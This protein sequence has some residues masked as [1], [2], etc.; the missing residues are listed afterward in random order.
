MTAAV[1]I[2]LLLTLQPPS[3]RL[4]ATADANLSAYHAEQNLNY[5]QS[6]HLRLKGI[7]MFALM[8]FDMEPIDGAE[9]GRAVLRFRSSRP[10][11]RLRTIG[12]YTVG[13]PW[14]EGTGRGT[15]A[16]G[17]NWLS[18]DGSG[19][20]WGPGPDFLAVSFTH[21][22]SR[23]AYSEIRDLG[24]R[25]LEVDVPPWLIHAMAV[26]ASHGL[27]VTDETGQ[28]YANNDIHSREQSGSEPY[29]LVEP[30]EEQ[31]SAPGPA[32]A[33]TV[34]PL[35]EEATL[36]AGAAR[37]QW[38]HVDD[39]FAYRC[40]VGDVELPRWRVPWP[41]RDAPVAT[42]DLTGL[43]PGAGL[44]VS[45][46]AVG[47]TGLEAPPMSGTG[48]ASEAWEPRVPLLSAPA[49]VEAPP[50]AEATGYSVH[51]GP[52]AGKVEPTRRPDLPGTGI[53]LAA[54]RNEFVC[55][56]IVVD[57]PEPL[58]EVHIQASELV[59]DAG[60]IPSPSLYRL[61]YVNDGGWVPEI[62]LPLDGPLSIPA[63]DN[64]I[65][66]QRNQSI[67]MEVYVPHGT[68]PGDY[69]GTLTVSAAGEAVDVPVGLTVGSP[70]LPDRLGFVLEL[71][72][73]GDVA[74]LFGVAPG[75]EEYIGIERAY[76]RAAHEH[77]ANW[78]P[79]P[80]NQAGRVI[81]GGAP[82]LEGS[83]DDMRVADWSAW[84]AR[85]GPLL[86]GSAFADM[87][88]AGV[89]VHGMYLPFHENWPSS[90]DNYTAGVDHPEYPGMVTEHALTAPPIQQAFGVQYVEQFVAIAREFAEH[91]RRRGWDEAW[92]HCYLNNKYYFKDPEQGGRGSSWWLLD[93]PM[94]RDDW[95][96]LR[97][98]ADMFRAGTAH[99]TPPFIS[100]G[101]ISRPQWQPRWMDGR[102]DL[103][104]VS[105]QLYEHHELCMR[106]DEEGAEMGYPVTF[107]HYGTAN[108]AGRP[109]TEA[110]AW[111]WSAFL[112][113]AD[114]ILPW[115]TIGTDANFEEPAATAILYPG[116]RLGIDGPV[117]SLRLKAM[118]RGV[119]DAEL[120]RL[121]LAREGAN[122]RDLRRALT[123]I[124][125]DALA[126]ETARDYAEDAGRLEFSALSEH[127][128]ADARR[129]VRAALG[130]GRLRD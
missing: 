31:P 124:L 90:M 78:N 95:L 50:L 85:Y 84:D 104:C 96:A 62:C 91:I 10:E 52:L 58:P 71:N 12:L 22:H 13:E 126:A 4:D 3:V 86:D 98:Y 89:P 29:L 122:R 123:P 67:L 127:V 74:H 28:T 30:R 59:G 61:W 21:G 106:I 55:A 130:D 97:F 83:G 53:V 119:Q 103:M 101:D 2:P 47:S 111:A 64:A 65:P 40:F 113:G 19:A 49:S 93:E 32:E 5:G 114:G 26:G 121:L 88:R 128:L 43:E 20:E 16:P 35:P 99:L 109:N 24:D 60:H 15:E 25:W 116:A 129:A 17:C 23:V 108:A 94:H 7:Q 79:L 110:V 8:E 112:A 81:A 6:S 66:G 107:W 48:Q 42:V 92:L 125:G 51:T 68:P 118:R 18:P 63:E 45:V 56:T 9:A 69:T 75:S 27:L 38:S 72:S 77:R 41:E 105:G 54:A 33:P 80:Y 87:P 76:H 14:L 46:V 39:A 36:N 117:A 11:H 44:R 1:L 120:M 37:I 100:R 82:P 57:S 102:F 73:Y 34:A 115:N 70:A